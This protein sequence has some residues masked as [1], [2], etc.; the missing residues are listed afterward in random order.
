MLK[1]KSPI[2]TSHYFSK[3]IILLTNP[4]EKS[5]RASIMVIQIYTFRFPQNDNILTLNRN[6]I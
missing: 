3:L 6:C 4:Y 2:P 5:I 1:N